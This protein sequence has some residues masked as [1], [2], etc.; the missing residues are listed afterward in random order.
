[1]L[2]T[3]SKGQNPAEKGKEEKERGPPLIRVKKR[4]YS[5]GFFSRGVCLKR[6]KSGHSN[7]QI[8][9]SGVKRKKAI[10][11]KKGGGGRDAKKRGGKRRNARGC[12]IIPKKKEKS[13]KVARVKKKETWP[14][15]EG[16]ER[17]EKKTLGTKGT[18][19]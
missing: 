14:R 4:I 18:V 17:G 3:I 10:V 1:V 13:S 16:G 8:K 15:E 2:V 9:T 11:K 12:T 5:E 6:K 7:R 19:R